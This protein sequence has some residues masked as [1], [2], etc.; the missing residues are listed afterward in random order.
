MSASGEHEGKMHTIKAFESQD[1]QIRELERKCA[2]L[3]DELRNGQCKNKS[4]T[5][6]FFCS[7]CK[8][9]LCLEDSGYEPTMLVDDVASAPKYCPSCGRK[10]VEE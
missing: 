7:E 1:E 4:V 8:C 6:N 9:F 3:E 10:V 5:G 2:E